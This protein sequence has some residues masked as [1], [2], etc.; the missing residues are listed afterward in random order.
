MIEGATSREFREF[1]VYTVL[2]LVVG[3]LTHENITFKRSYNFN[4]SKEIKLQLSILI[5]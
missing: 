5:C 2:K 4:L 1:L 3:N